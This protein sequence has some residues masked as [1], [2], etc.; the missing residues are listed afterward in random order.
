MRFADAY[1]CFKFRGAPRRFTARGNQSR[2]ES[3]CPGYCGVQDIFY[4]DHLKASGASAAESAEVYVA[5]TPTH[6]MLQRRISFSCLL[7]EGALSGA[8]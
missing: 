8:L 6:S 4:V 2:L 5:H 3:E 7:R 1:Y